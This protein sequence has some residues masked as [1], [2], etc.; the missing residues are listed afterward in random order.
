MSMTTPFGPTVMRQI[1]VLALARSAGLH[2]LAE[3]RLG[4][5][6]G[7]GTPGAGAVA[8]AV[9]AGRRSPRDH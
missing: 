3:E 6:T 7:P 8:V 5:V 4:A 2:E 1:P 9:R